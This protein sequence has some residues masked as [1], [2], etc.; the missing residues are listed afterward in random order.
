[1]LNA[2]VILSTREVKRGF[3]QKLSIELGTGFDGTH[4]VSMETG[5]DR[6]VSHVDYQRFWI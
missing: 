1:M 4:T 5:E 3:A 6:W 2:G